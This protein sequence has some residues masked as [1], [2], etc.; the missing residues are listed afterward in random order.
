[1]RGT[2]RNIETRAEAEAEVAQSMDY[3]E[4]RAGTRPKFFAYPW[5]ESSTY[6]HAEYLPTRGVELGLWAALSGTETSTGYVT[7]ASNRWL[8]PRFVCQHD[9]KSPAG[10]ED[11]LRGLV[12]AA[13]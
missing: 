9:W 4:E 1:M 6:L 11:L 3:I 2:F 10:L 7:R 8:V 12:A 5:G 13:A